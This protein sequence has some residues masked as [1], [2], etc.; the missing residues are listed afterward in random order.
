VAEER[1]LNILIVDDDLDARELLLLA[2]QR[3]GISSRVCCVNGGNEAVAYLRGDAAFADRERFPYPSLLITDLKMSDGDGFT[4][5]DQL[6]GM[7]RYRVV[8]TIVMSASADPDDIRKAYMLGATSYFVKPAGVRGSGAPAQAPVRDLAARG[9]S[10]S[11]YHGQTSRHA[12]RRQARREVSSGSVTGAAASGAQRPPI[13]EIAAHVAGTGSALQ[14]G[15]IED[16]DRSA[17]IVDPSAQRESRPLDVLQ[18][19]TR[20]TRASGE[21]GRCRHAGGS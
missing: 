13:D 6:R 2:L 18:A 17:A 19:C 10:G 3:I 5:L 14:P 16:R 11:R 4:L 20:G 9:D 1:L 21:T 12:Q 15:R 7:P 8:P